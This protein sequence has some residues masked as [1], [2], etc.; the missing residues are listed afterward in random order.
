MDVF[1][2][3]GILLSDG[4]SGDSMLTMIR[5]NSLLLNEDSTRVPFE[6]IQVGDIICF[7][8]RTGARLS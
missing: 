4:L 1:L 7:Q 6:A 2:A 3:H 8:K 5:D